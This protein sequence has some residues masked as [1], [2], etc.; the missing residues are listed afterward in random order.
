MRIGF[1][2]KYRGNCNTMSD[3]PRERAPNRACLEGMVLLRIWPASSYFEILAVSFKRS[4]PSRTLKCVD[5][6]PD[7][8]AGCDLNE[9]TRPTSLRSLGSGYWKDKNVGRWQ[10]WIMC[11]RLL[12]GKGV[13]ERARLVGAVM[14]STCCCGANERLAIMPSAKLAVPDQKARALRCPD[15]SGF[16]R[17]SVFDRLIAL[18]LFALPKLVGTQCGHVWRWR[19]AYSC[20]YRSLSYGTKHQLRSAALRSAPR[21]SACSVA[22]RPRRS[23]PHPPRRSSVD[24]VHLELTCR[25]PIIPS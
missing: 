15:R 4:S 6:G 19:S 5:P 21:Q 2:Y 1:P 3:R 9:N 17:L 14:C 20:Q 7:Q 12:V 24:T 10:L 11:G 23:P 8:A 18:I 25:C 16:F 13:L 22:S